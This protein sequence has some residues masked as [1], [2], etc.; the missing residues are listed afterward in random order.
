M[1]IPHYDTVRDTPLPTD[2]E[3]IP[4]IRLMLDRPLRRQVW[5][6]LLDRDSKPLPIVMPVELDDE[7]DSDNVAGYA[8]MLRCLSWDFE[9]VTL[10]LT[11]ERPG[12]ADIVD[13]DRRWLR[14]LLEACVESD[15]GFRGPYLFIGSTVR[16][17]PSE[18]YVGIPWVYSSHDEYAEYD[19]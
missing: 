7:P 12:P 1:P 10:V 14:L 3:L 6:M 15:C 13:N 18:E 9:S 4:H 17:I 5:V 11:L 19:D 2:A 16:A 8:D